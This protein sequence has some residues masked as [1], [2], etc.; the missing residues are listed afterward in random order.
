[1][2]NRPFKTPTNQELENLL[3]P[4]YANKTKTG[5]KYALNMLRSYLNHKNIIE[6]P[7]LAQE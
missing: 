7:H 4:K 5:I 2:A 3:Q 1:M 6:I